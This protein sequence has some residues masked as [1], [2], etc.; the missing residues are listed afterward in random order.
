MNAA[1]S[2]LA[3]RH[4]KPA[5]AS[6]R[7]QLSF[8]EVKSRRQH[9]RNGGDDTH[10]LGHFGWLVAAAQRADADPIMLCSMLSQG[11]SCQCL[12]VAKH[13]DQV[14]AVGG[15]VV[16]VEL[17]REQRRKLFRMAD[18]LAD[19]AALNSRDVGPGVG[20]VNLPVL[21]VV[22]AAPELPGPLQCLLLACADLTIEWRQ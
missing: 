18:I 9:L 13:V 14:E 5:L 20:A 11:A 8:T 2:K 19:S 21:S 3:M 6:A 10:Q 12:A 4:I 16:V 17:L 22:V 1:V 15:V 7:R